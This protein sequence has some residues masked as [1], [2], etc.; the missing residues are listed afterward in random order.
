[1][2][3]SSYHLDSFSS[4][5]LGPEHGENLAGVQLPQ[6]DLVHQ[7]APGLFDTLP[8][9][10]LTDAHRAL[11]NWPHAGDRDASGASFAGVAAWVSGVA[12]ALL[13]HGLEQHSFAGAHF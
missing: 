6:A 11:Q 10:F 12:L 13:W 1:M 9:E 2:T 3:A 4:T 8:E 7:T 5:E